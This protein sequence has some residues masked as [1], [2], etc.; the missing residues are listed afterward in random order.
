M[1]KSA[2]YLAILILS[3]TGSLHA[4]TVELFELQKKCAVEAKKY[5]LENKSD[6]TPPR[7]GNTVLYEYHYNKKRGLC[8]L[9][10]Y[11]SNG[12]FPYFTFD[13]VLSV[14]ENKSIASYHEGIN[15]KNESKVMICNYDGKKCS[16]STE[17][18]KIIGNLMF[19]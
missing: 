10:V 17:F 11:G 16:S 13:S 12:N 2:Y 7:S 6:I 3:C 14:L 8:L 15:D 5:Y 18:E 1:N 19:E 9:R 4:Q